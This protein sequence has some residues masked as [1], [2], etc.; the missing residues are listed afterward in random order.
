MVV[1]AILLTPGGEHGMVPFVVVMAVEMLM[2]TCLVA[3]VAIATESQGWTI[4]STQ[5]G[6]LGLNGIGWW[7]AGLPGIARTMHSKTVNWSPTATALVSSELGLI[8]LMFA[9]TFYVQMR[10]RDFV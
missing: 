1:G 3:A 4:G 7:I 5:V 9:V 2:S 8:V 10:K 6:V